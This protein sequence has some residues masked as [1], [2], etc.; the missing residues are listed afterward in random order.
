MHLGVLVEQI[1]EI[2]GRMQIKSIDKM[3]G[4]YL[5]DLEMDDST[6]MGE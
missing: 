5:L 1:Q 4:V 3:C 6:Q 2:A